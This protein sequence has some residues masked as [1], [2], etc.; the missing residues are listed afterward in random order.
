MEISNDQVQ[1]PT[2]LGNSQEHFRIAA[3]RQ[4]LPLSKRP[5][6]WATEILPRLYR[7]VVVTR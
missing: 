1:L 6:V 2:G 3:V 5:L 4:L 7:S